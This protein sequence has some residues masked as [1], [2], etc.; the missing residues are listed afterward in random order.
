MFALGE[1]MRN[2]HYLLL[3]YFMCM[4]THGFPSSLASLSRSVGHYYY[5]MVMIIYIFA[6]GFDECSDAA[7]SDIDAGG[8]I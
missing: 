3:I 6:G 7:T 8:R 2:G 5:D 1:S 4:W